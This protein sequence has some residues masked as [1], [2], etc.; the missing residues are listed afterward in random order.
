MSRFMLSAGLAALTATAPAFAQDNRITEDLSPQCL[1]LFVFADES[2][3]YEVD[4]MP[5]LL[6]VIE[7][8]NV[9]ECRTTLRRLQSE[10][11]Q[12]RRVVTGRDSDD[13]QDDPRQ[14]R[15]TDRDTETETVTT[16]EREQVRKQVELEQTVVVAGSVDVAQE[17]PEVTVEQSAPQVQVRG[18]QPEVSVRSSKPEIVVKERPATVRVGMPT[19]TIEQPA[20]VIE[21]FMPDPDVRIAG[22]EPEV[23]VRQAAPRVSVTMPDPEVNLDLA[24]RPAG[25]AG[26]VTTRIR[27]LQGQTRERNG[28]T[29]LDDGEVDSN[30]RVYI[31]EAEAQIERMQDEGSEEDRLDIRTEEP[32]VRFVR[33]EATVEIDGE[34]DV[35]FERVGEPRVTF[36]RDREGQETTV[37]DL[38]DMEVRSRDGEKIGQIERVVSLSGNTYA[39]LS[40]GGFFGVG[41]KEIPLPLSNLSVQ[42][43]Y[44]VSDNL[45]KDEVENLSDQDLSDDLALTEDEPLRIRSQRRS[46]E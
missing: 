43:D 23:T 7:R 35:R 20:P 29:L 27:R 5:E 46:G 41:G 39:V 1:E 38:M 28:M 17:V 13:E 37:G 19:I 22:G 25:E 44:L 16:T 14:R 3:N 4:G 40:H 11:R 33:A 45:T 24:A 15:R 30:A 2:D 6:A 34:P 36:L 9:R 32:T 8:D 42:D 18:G 26:E 21:V 10:E 12:A 31:R